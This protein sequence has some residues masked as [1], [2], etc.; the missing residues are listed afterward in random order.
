[1]LENFVNTILEGDCLELIDRL[2]ENSIDSIVTDPPYEL[3]IMRKGWDSSGISFNPEIWKKCLRVLKPGGFLLS[4]S[5]SKTYHRIAVAIED[6]GFEIV[7]MIE[8][9]YNSGFPK[10]M[11]IAKA[12]DRK[13]GAKP[14]TFKE[15]IYADGR[16]QNDANA[17]NWRDTL[18]INSSKIKQRHGNVLNFNQ[19]NSG[20]VDATNRRNYR[21]EYSPVTEEAKK[22]KGWH[23]QLKPAH[24]PI[25]VAQKRIAEKTIVDNIMKHETGGLNI[26][27]CAIPSEKPFMVHG[28]FVKRN[29]VDNFIPHTDPGSF[30]GKEYKV[31]AS[32][33]YVEKTSRFPAN[34]IVQDNALDNRKASKN[35]YMDQEVRDC[36]RFYSLDSWW[37]NKI[38]Q[39]P[40]SVQK[41]F[42]FIL[43]AK[44]TSKEK[45]AG[46]LNL[47][48]EKK[49]RFNSETNSGDFSQK[50]MFYRNLRKNEQRKV[51]KGN[52]HETV[53]PVNLIGYLITLVT[54]PNGIV[55][56]PFIGSGTTAVAA[57][58]LSRRWIGIEKD[59]YYIEIAAAR[60]NFIL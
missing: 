14:T 1:M 33:E 28:Y 17:K 38:K 13:L 27:E 24:E 39:L 29:I 30:I 42:P 45:D 52:F 54:P 59:P 8:W 58:I 51:M 41:T 48:I 34:L 3:S 32:L 18:G 36:S 37:E 49:S 53:K 44:P 15:K 43:V 25:I 10:G 31:Q 46:C 22:W 7:D 23:T 60:I 50:L 5:S 12:I 26:D 16:S 57:K 20:W 55:L 21:Y 11:N 2:P 6:A 4:F 19:E 35:D 9:V 47:N 56:D 40:E